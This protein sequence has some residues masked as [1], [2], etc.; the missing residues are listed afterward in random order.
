MPDTADDDLHMTRALELALNGEGLVEPNPMVGCVIVNGGSVVGEG[1]HDRF[2]GPHAE[3][4]ALEAAGRR[5]E[6]ATLYV[7]L[8]PCC[9]YGKTPPCVAAIV[10]AGISRVVAAMSDPYV[11]VAG[12]GLVELAQAGIRITAGRL[13]G[14]AR[15]SMRPTSSASLP[16]APG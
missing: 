14:D 4:M 6:G 3:I 10:K 2:G 13:E 8:E 9:H 15:G 7:T 5:A 1:W 11:E 16:A 12:R